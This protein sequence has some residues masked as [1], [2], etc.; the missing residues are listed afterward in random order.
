MMP[1]VSIVTPAFNAAATIGRCIES[2]RSQSFGDWE[3]IIVD[4]GS[5]DETVEVV[6]RYASGDNRLRLVQQ[7]KNRGA[8]PARNAA[9]A[10]ARGRYIAFLD[11]DD[12]WYPEKL[13]KV[14]QFMKSKGAPFAYHDYDIFGKDGAHRVTT[15]AP[16][17]M[18]Y[19]DLLKNT[20]IGCLT[21]VIDGEKIRIPEM[22]AIPLRQPLVAWLSIL[23]TGV[24][25]RK[26]EGVHAAY[27]LTEN[28]ISS[29]KV[30]AIIWTWKVYRQFERIP[31]LAS[32]RLMVGYVFNAVVKNSG[33]AGRRSGG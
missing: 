5:S 17:S 10:T 26:A 12:E 32:A 2:V 22:P 33:L 19:R 4:D 23:S 15:S 16:G 13:E 3:Q 31:R 14:L 24:V 6:R 29:N 9:I 18:T 30:K 27:H 8:G 20:A 7:G 11:A 28:S 21:V 25:A 1:E